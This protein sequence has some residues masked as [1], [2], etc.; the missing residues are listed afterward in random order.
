[1]TKAIALFS[2]G[3]DS[4][5][6]C[7]VVARQGIEVI[8]VR[9]ISPFF[10]YDL[11]L[12]PS[13]SAEMKAKYGIEIMLRD[14][15][16]EYMALLRAPAHGY[17]KNFN[18]CLDCK[19]FM[20]TKAREMMQELGA[21]F[22]ISGEVLGQRP[23]SQRRDALRVVERDSGCDGIL[24]RPL[25]AK[26]LNPTRPE[27][28]GVVDRSQLCDFSGRGRSQQIA[29]AKE[30]GVVD[31]PTPSGGC[32]LTDVN[33]SG[34]IKRYYEENEVLHV[35]DMRL[36]TLGRHYLLPG[37][38]WLAMGRGEVEN[39]KVLSLAGP[40]DVTMKLVDRP[41]PTA[42]VRNLREASDLAIAAGMV[43]RYGKK[44]ED[45]LPLPGEVESVGASGS[46][47]LVGV[48]P[49]DSLSHAWL[50]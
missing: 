12:D 33:V 50:R 1:V 41:G 2:G 32:V 34:R 26:H 29:L 36:L 23:M 22:L 3:L 27:L 30:M 16:A 46:T 38:A 40:E 48:P 20:M 18:P 8:A 17:G 39:A 15:S 4:I 37:G 25:C 31:Y 28:E 21:T 43:A 10:N 5:L 47:I 11:L 14:I 24:L 42:L 49:E 7:R 35:A 9:F 44:G 45:G 6:A 13:Y 19:I